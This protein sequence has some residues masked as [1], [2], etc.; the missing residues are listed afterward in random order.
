MIPAME[1]RFYEAQI[2]T[3]KKN[4]I[5]YYFADSIKVEL[6]RSLTL[7]LPNSVD[8]FEKNL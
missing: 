2:F 6:L 8:N 5:I 1:L 4:R 7:N 3:D